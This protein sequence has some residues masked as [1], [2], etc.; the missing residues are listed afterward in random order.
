MMSPVRLFRRFAVALYWLVLPLCLAAFVVSFAAI[1][2]DGAYQPEWR[3]ALGAVVVALVIGWRLRLN[4]RALGSR[5]KI[6]SAGRLATVFVPLGVLSAL[7]AALVLLGMMWIGLGGWMLLDDQAGAS[8]LTYSD[9]A[10]ATATSV[11]L[12]V[13]GLALVG[14]GGLPNWFFW[15][16]FRRRETQVV[17]PDSKDELARVED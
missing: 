16:L 13:T 11:A 5:S 15:R 10:S 17:L 14:L 12:I 9:D 1:G 6:P 2:E 3:L 7:G 8:L 4:S